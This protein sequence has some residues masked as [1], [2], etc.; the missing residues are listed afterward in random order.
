MSLGLL[1]RLHGF[2]VEETEKVEGIREVF[3]RLFSCKPRDSEVEFIKSFDEVGFLG[4]KVLIPVIFDGDRVVGSSVLDIRT[5]MLGKY[6]VEVVRSLPWLVWD[7]MVWMCV[8]QNQ[9]SVG[10][11][12]LEGGLQ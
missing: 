8:P 9:A 10:I 5:W 7:L 2:Y 3:E 11:Y 6:A 12:K 4:T 1:G